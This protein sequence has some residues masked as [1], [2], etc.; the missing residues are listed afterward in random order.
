VHR[1]ALGEVNIPTPEYNNF[2]IF[3]SLSGSP[4]LASGVQFPSTSPRSSGQRLGCYLTTLFGNVDITTAVPMEATRPKRKHGMLPIL[5]ILFCIS[6]GLMTMLIVEQGS[7]IESQRA[8]IHELFRDS[9]ALNR[10]RAKELQEK[11]A[12][13][14]SQAQAPVMQTPSTQTPSTQAPNQAPSSQAAP[15]KQHAMPKPFQPPQ[16]ATDQA[17]DRR[18]L[19]R[20]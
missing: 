16:P 5:T 4:L 7:T 10:Y 15:Q 13:R 17:H 6:Y 3:N 19:I 1:L 8:L 11:Q 9:M 14:N 12:A 18:A 20:I 2:G